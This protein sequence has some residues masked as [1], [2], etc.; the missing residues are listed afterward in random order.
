MKRLVTNSTSSRHTA[1]LT[2]P[3]PTI[4]A[5]ILA[6]VL[7]FF[8]LI[9]TANSANATI[10]EIHP[11][12]GGDYPTIQD[13]LDI[14]FEG[15]TVLL[16]DGIF[17]GSG[18]TSLD[19]G[20]TDLILRSENGPQATII[21]GGG[22][23]Y[24]IWFQ[25]D[26][27]SAAVVEGIAFTRAPEGSAIQITGGA[28]PTFNDCIIYNNHVTTN[29]GGGVYISYSSPQFNGCDIVD[30]MVDYHGGGVWIAGGE[31]SFV[32]CQIVGNIAQRNGGGLCITGGASVTIERCTISANRA[33]EE[34][35]GHDGGGIALI[36]IGT[37]ATIE[38]TI[39]WGNQA[40][41]Y[42]ELFAA[43]P[44]TAT[45]TCCDVDA[46]GVGGAGTVVLGSD[47][48]ALEPHFCQPSYTLLDAWYNGNYGLATNSPCLSGHMDNPCG[49]H[50]G[51]EGSVCGDVFVWTGGG[52]TTA[53][54]DPA[55]WNLPAVPGI[56]DQ[57]QL[58][59]GNVVLSSL[60]SIDR[61]LQIPESLAAPDTFRIASGG[62]LHLGFGRSGNGNG[63]GKGDGSAEGSG[64]ARGAKDET[65]EQYRPPEN[66][67]PTG[68][69]AGGHTIHEEGSDGITAASEGDLPYHILVDYYG[70]YVMFG[71]NLAG[72]LLVD[73][74]GRFMLGGPGINVLD[75]AFANYGDGTGD[76]LRGMYA[77]NG[78]VVANDLGD[79]YGQM[80]VAAGAEFEVNDTFVV[81]PDAGFTVSGHLTGIGAANNYGTIGKYNQATSLMSLNLNNLRSDILR[82]TGTIEIAGGTWHATGTLTNDGQ[83]DIAAGAVLALDGTLDNNSDGVV[84]IVGDMTG[85]GVFEN[86]GLLSKADS[87]TSNI[88]PLINNRFDTS[89]GDRGIVQ[90]SAGA[91]NT[92]NLVNEGRIASGNSSVLA[93]QNHL[94]NQ[95]SGVIAGKGQID[96]TSI[97][98]TNEGDISPGF[99]PGA[100]A[101]AGDLT[102]GSPSAL[103]I[104]IGGTDAGNE[105]DQLNVA[106]TVTFGGA[107]HVS[108]ID[109]FVPS[110]GNV[111]T[112]VTF[113]GD[114]PPFPGFDCFSGLQVDG[115]PFLAPR[116]RE[117]S[118]VL[119]A[120]DTTITN[121]SIPEAVDD[122]YG[123]DWTMPI[124]LLPLEN[125]HDGDPGDTLSL[126]ALITEST[127]G[128]A[129][130]DPGYTT[131]TY[132]P[133]F[134]FT[135]NDTL[136]YVVTDCNG[137]S[138]SAEIV[139][140]L[141]DIDGVPGT[142]ATPG[143]YRLHPNY[144]NPFNPVTR[145]RFDLPEAGVVRL[146]VYDLRGQRIRS[147]ADGYHAAGTFAADWRGRDDKG[148][149]VA[150]GVYFARLEA[151]PY[152]AVRKMMLL[153]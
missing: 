136:V 152:V 144:P 44:T 150:S 148:R 35:G 92:L 26:E 64:G 8:I 29:N 135:G 28:S 137:A 78:T 141:D 2:T 41:Q 133:S 60:A 15:D 89:T 142:N 109:D 71:S 11:D 94:V 43:G 19:F 77:V 112:V 62:E 72:D 69:V 18:N 5:I 1:A 113:Q 50:I 67:P 123:T 97:D 121:N 9:F 73:I 56:M 22:A 32:D 96:G 74:Y 40:T 17:T 20:G 84:T 143:A 31:P 39:L 116:L 153:K 51:A 36:G 124:T 76:P 93:V 85:D 98:F 101:Y 129:F 134:D 68:S 21:D 138:D 27:T 146:N 102:L 140:T 34:D 151:G 57:A 114:P 59:R 99:S 107:L 86:Y 3:L 90:I 45:F 120:V 58:S 52:G 126:A 115:A 88:Q 7:S 103:H 12:G 37:E 130:I 79:N 61:F 117:D 110:I 53:W 111:F 30:N 80:A 55:N 33:D 106:G 100:L 119:V 105:Y 14:A 95:L 63:S 65:E 54:E 91:L 75:A 46:P 42:D 13:A 16:V 128:E 10:H 23:G 38:Q 104:E 49:L 127:L 83:I 125:D 122:T 87:G 108:L 66:R 70:I 131:I 82:A 6:V 81:H 24:V 47:S 147:L 25:N 4:L 118:F 48:I 149:R 132:L 139:I 145:I